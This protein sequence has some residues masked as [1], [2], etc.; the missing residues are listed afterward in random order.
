MNYNRYRKKELIERISYLENELNRKWS[1]E[2][3][4]S[5]IYDSLDSTLNGVAITDLHGII[6]YVNP[7]FLNMFE[8][9]SRDSVI[10]NYAADIFVAS[11]ISNISDIERILKKER[12]KKL[13]FDV[14]RND[15]T[16]FQV[17]ISASSVKGS[18]VE[19]GTILSF[20][21]IT[22]RKRIEK[23]NR[24]LSLMV[25][26]SQE[27]E[28]QRVSK[29]LH[30][31]VGQT[32]LAAKL[33]FLAYQNDNMK[34]KERFITGLKFI[35]TAS[36]ELREIYED[37]Y[38]SLLSDM[39]LESTIRWYSK[40]SLEINKIKANL[41]IHL[42]EQF[43]HNLE[44]DLYRIIKELFSNIIKHSGA[45]SV[46]FYLSGKSGDVKLSI[47]DNGCGFNMENPEN[48]KKGFG[49]N[50]IRQRVNSHGG[51]FIINSSKDRGTSIIINI[52][53][54]QS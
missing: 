37:L 30:D 9:D 50:N 38:P 24:R 21:D 53:V 42:D 22:E 31:G 35:D 11:K 19:V 41:N 52:K 13:E 26:K 48:N 6:R 29:D 20:N 34:H 44:V 15:G 39:G 1:E 10:G 18:G 45:D 2:H 32:I 23:E 47:T 54:E 7:S 46:Y 36:S 17:E 49:L 5:L 4:I 8:Y 12:D 33:N 16:I 14:Y 28:R 3:Y 40:N 51:S 25:I 27:L 43:P